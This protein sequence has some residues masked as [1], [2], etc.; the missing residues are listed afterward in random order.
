MSIAHPSSPCVV[1]LSS[2]PE[3]KTGTVYIL[4]PSSTLKINEDE[5]VDFTPQSS[6]ENYLGN[7]KNLQL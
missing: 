3:A 4:D 1:I 6:L 2:G 5:G 7:I